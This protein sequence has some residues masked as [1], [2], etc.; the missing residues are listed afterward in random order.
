M[1][2]PTGRPVRGAVGGI[3]T[4]LALA[5]VLQQAG[6]WPLDTLSLYVLPVALA[7]V[8]YIIGRAAPFGGEK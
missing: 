6:I 2:K 4:G 5:L 8:G 1:A 7:A 3:I